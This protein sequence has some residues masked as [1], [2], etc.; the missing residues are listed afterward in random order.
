MILISLTIFIARILDVSLGTIR[1]ILLVKG[2]KGAASVVAFVEITIWFLIVREALA[3]ASEHP[4]IIIA[5]AG[6]FT[7]G[8]YIGSFLSEKYISGTLNVQVISAKSEELIRAIRDNDFAVSAV[9]VKGLEKDVKRVM[10][11][12]EINKKDLNK[13]RSIIKS[14]DERAFVIVNESKLVQNG[15]FQRQI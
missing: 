15:Y 3:V 14:I 11:F 2:R 8:T 5:Y 7:A 4:W 1:T 10:L 6:G 9:D 12:I 13:L